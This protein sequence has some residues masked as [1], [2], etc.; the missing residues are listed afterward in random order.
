MRAKAP[1]YGER[2]RE[3]GEGEER[4]LL[5]SLVYYYTRQ[6]SLHRL[7]CRRGKSNIAQNIG[8]EISTF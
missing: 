4:G 6:I 2:E 5:L 3:G 7:I 8:Y 1:F